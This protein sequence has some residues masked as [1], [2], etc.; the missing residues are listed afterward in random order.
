MDGNETNMGKD[1]LAYSTARFEAHMLTQATD[2]SH[3]MALYLGGTHFDDQPPNNR[4][5]G[6]MRY[7]AL[8]SGKRLRPFL[9]LEAAAV[10]GAPRDAALRIGC[11]IECIH[12][13]SLIHDDLP[14]M[15]DDDLR[16]G[17]PTVHKAYDE[18]TAILAGDGLL[19]MAF[20][21][22]TLDDGLISPSSQAL[23]V[24]LLAK[25]A[26][27]KG[28]VGGQML[29]LMAGPEQSFAQMEAMQAL[30]TGAL[31]AA[32]IEASLCLINCDEVEARA[33]KSFGRDLGL[34][35]QITDDILDEEGDAALMGK[36]A[37][38]KDRMRGKVNF[39]T[40]LGLQTAKNL[41]QKVKAKALE[42]LAPFAD[43]AQ[44]LRETVDFVTNRSH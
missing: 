14:S 41:A 43:R 19:T 35:F 5:L 3:E 9:T 22:I 15:D 24:K 32:S 28:M 30:K 29:D 10:L 23:L 34:L 27:A 40:I 16:R 31:I 37:G 18:A 4:L 20:E 13:Y 7:G 38:S 33:L 44:N 25:A 36:A 17:M 2:I 39:V 1:G 11:A 21:I 6:A 12:A 42:A 8:G 26:G